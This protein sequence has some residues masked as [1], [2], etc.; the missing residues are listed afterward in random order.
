[1]CQDIKLWCFSCEQCRR[2]KGPGARHRVP[3]PVHTVGVPWERV[4]VEI[5][6]P[7]NNTSRCN[8]YL[9]VAVDYINRWPEAT[10]VPSQRSEVVAWALVGIIFKRFAALALSKRQ[11]QGQNRDQRPPNSPYRPKTPFR[12]FGPI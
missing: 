8:K 7:F 12:N 3:L 9:I 5:A 11:R 1:M 10:P 6:G 2:K 4:A